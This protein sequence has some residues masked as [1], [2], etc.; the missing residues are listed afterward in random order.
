M[1]IESSGVVS[2]SAYFSYWISKDDDMLT[3]D[4]NTPR[5]SNGRTTTVT[6]DGERLRLIASGQEDGTL[7]GIVVGW[8]K[9]GTGTAGLMDAYAT[10]ITAGIEHGVP[11]AAL[12]RPGLGL[13][14]APCGSTNDPDI[15]RTR[16]AVDY[17]SR[18]LAI[19]W[20]PGDERATLGL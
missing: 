8:G 4:W 20:L 15:P 10:A 14:F 5:R 2:G 16:S 6:I 19:D 12:L 9:Y 18:R 3:P 1:P 17:L 7:S 11:L 13:R